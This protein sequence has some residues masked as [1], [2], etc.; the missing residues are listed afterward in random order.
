MQCPED[1]IQPVKN[2]VA[3]NL[4]V[5]LSQRSFPGF[6]LSY[7]KPGGTSSWF[8][9]MQ[10]QIFSGILWYSVLC[11]TPHQEHGASG[12]RFSCSE[13][14]ERLGFTQFNFLKFS[15]VFPKI[16]R[17]FGKIVMFLPSCVFILLSPLPLIL[18]LSLFL[19]VLCFP[20][21]IGIFLLQL[22]GGCSPGGI[23]VRSCQLGLLSSSDETF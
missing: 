7:T 4:T 2:S 10:F 8:P 16:C 12:V 17:F 13:G 6:E 3:L 1:E 5:I 14:C 18:F 20:C 11:N 22:K 15:Y 21:V 9:F 19:P 23:R